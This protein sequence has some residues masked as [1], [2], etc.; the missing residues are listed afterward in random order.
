MPSSPLGS[1]PLKAEVGGDR[2]KNE[3]K[4]LEPRRL[5][6]PK[7]M[8]LLETEVGVPTQDLAEVRVEHQIAGDS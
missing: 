1:Y 2:K 8:L 6:P 4:P 5:S 7:G 3:N